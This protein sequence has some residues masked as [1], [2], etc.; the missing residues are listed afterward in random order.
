[1][2]MDRKWTTLESSTEFKGLIN[3]LSEWCA[4][5]IA[6]TQDGKKMVSEGLSDLPESDKTSKDC[7]WWRDDYLVYQIFI[8]DTSTHKQLMQL[9][10]HKGLIT[11]LATYDD[12]IVSSSL[13]GTIRVWDISTGCQLQVQDCKNPIISITCSSAAEA[14]PLIAV[15]TGSARHASRSSSTASQAPTTNLN[16]WDLSTGQLQATMPLGYANTSY[17]MSAIS[18]DGRKLV[19]GSQ[20]GSVVVW[21]LSTRRP[22]HHLKAPGTIVS[23]AFSADGK[24]VAIG[25]NHR[26]VRIWC[27]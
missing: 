11:S 24:R 17:C 9:K 27:L 23:I 20:D 4:T 2:M 5:S 10:G 13:D 26:F 3:R 25:D 7:F 14:E 1:M 15:C 16:L 22:L 12:K 21:D 18:P 8:W 6:Y 19:S